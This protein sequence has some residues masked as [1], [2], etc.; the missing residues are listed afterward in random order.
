MLDRMAGTG[1]LG[2]LATVAALVVVLAGC[3]ASPTTG[4]AANGTLANAAKSRLEGDPYQAGSR[5]PGPTVKL[6]R[7]TIQMGRTGIHPGGGG[8]QK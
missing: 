3:S 1:R 5:A 8:P 2:G 7:A 4:A 6:T